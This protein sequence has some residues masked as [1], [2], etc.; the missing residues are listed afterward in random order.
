MNLMFL[1]GTR[2]QT[3]THTHTYTNTHTHGRIMV[4]SDK[5]QLSN[6]IMTLYF[7]RYNNHS[8]R[9]LMNSARHI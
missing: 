9:A 7:I 6:K 2:T 5:Q 4:G 1:S 8:G 3:Y